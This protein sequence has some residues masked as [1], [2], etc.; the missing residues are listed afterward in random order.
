MDV[1][2]FI[3]INYYNN[4]TLTRSEEIIA[5]LNFNEVKIRKEK[6]KRP[7]R[8]ESELISDQ[9]LRISFRAVLFFEDVM[10]L[11]FP[12]ACTCLA[13]TATWEVLPRTF[14]STAAV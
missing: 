3:R 11:F 9:D 8:D 2:K 10:P 12:L 5:K 13:P 4:A 1:G 14:F 7:F 6:E